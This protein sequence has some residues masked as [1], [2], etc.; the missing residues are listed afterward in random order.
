MLIETSR[1]VATSKLSWLLED[2]TLTLTGPG[3]VEDTL[4]GKSRIRLDRISIYENA[5]SM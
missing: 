5:M 3:K 1:R 2:F 4:S